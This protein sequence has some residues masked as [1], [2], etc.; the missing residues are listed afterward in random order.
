MSGGYDREALKAIMPPAE[1]AALE[2]QEQENRAAFQAMFA[3]STVRDRIVEV[4]NKYG[5]S[6]PN[7]PLDALTAAMERIGARMQQ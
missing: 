3:A 6:L 1:F 5:V 7:A 4:L 2:K